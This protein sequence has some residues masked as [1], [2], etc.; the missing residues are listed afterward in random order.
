MN[1]FHPYNSGWCGE[2]TESAASVKT[3][4][5]YQSFCDTMGVDAGENLTCKGMG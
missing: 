1:V 3:A 5:Y 2:A 4:Q